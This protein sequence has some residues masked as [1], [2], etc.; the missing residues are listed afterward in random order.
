MGLTYYGVGSI[1][2]FMK[3]LMK[4]MTEA[5]RA[6]VREYR[7]RRKAAKYRPLEIGNTRVKFADGSVSATYP[8]LACAKMQQ[9]HFALINPA[10]Q[11][12]TLEQWDGQGWVPREE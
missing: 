5:E 11:G 1:I 4:D 7:A 9:K 8:D 12:S 10:A 3:R 2:G 6:E